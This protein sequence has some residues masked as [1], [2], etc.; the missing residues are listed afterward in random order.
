[1]P[2]FL[3]CCCS[4]VR[5]CFSFTQYGDEAI[6]KVLSASWKHCS[7]VKE[8]LYIFG[9][10]IPRRNQHRKRHVF[11]LWKACFKVRVNIVGLIARGSRRLELARLLH[12]SF[13]CR[14]GTLVSRRSSCPC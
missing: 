5:A 3:C 8:D 13:S 11:V 12:F 2:L 4:A 7:N 14:W 1:M 9:A 6:S 10:I